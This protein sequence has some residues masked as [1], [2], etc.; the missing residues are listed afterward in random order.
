M[1]F[2]SLDC[3][4]TMLTSNRRPWFQFSVATMFVVVTVVAIGI[5]ST[6]GLAMLV[7]VGVS[8]LGL[9]VVHISHEFSRWGSQYIV[10]TLGWSL[11]LVVSLLIIPVLFLS[12]L[13]AVLSQ[14]R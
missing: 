14:S 7:C 8:I 6:F 11:F 4:A 10:A 9:W 2:Q 12:E 3:I 5:D 1:P 13:P